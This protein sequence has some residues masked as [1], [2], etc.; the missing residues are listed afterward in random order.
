MSPYPPTWQQAWEAAQ[1][2]IET[3][4]NSLPRFPYV[5]LQNL[6]VGQLD[7]ELLDQELLQIL[8]EP[9][10][11]ALG[12]IQVHLLLFRYP[13]SDCNTQSSYRS[14]VEPELTLALHIFL[15]KFSVWDAGATYGAKLQNMRYKIPRAPGS[16]SLARESLKSML[17]S[18]D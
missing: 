2:R 13:I 7:A 8:S 3:I 16:S 15:Y 11:K 9:I 4:R 18:T 12:L 17:H 5:S 14:R 10:S 1:P 6:R